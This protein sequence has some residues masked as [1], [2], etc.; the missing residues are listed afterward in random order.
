MNIIERGRGFVQWL[1]E[2][3]QRSLWDWRRC[4][5]C[6][7]DQTIRNGGYW[8]RP[9]TFEGRQRVRVQRHRCY[10]CGR[11]YIEERAWLVRGSWYG[12][13]VH[14]WAVDCW[15]YARSSLRRSAEMARSWLG[16]QERWGMW[17]PWEEGAAG[18][19]RCR[20]SAS[21]VQRWLGRAGQ[22]ARESVPEHLQGLGS[23]GQFGSDGLWVR[24]RGGG[25]RVVLSLVDSVSGLVWGL[26]VAV[27]EESAAEW[28]KLFERAREAGL[29]W[30]KLNGLTSDGAQGLLA[31]LRQTL[32][33]VHHQRCVWHFWRSLGAELGKAVAKAAKG[34]TKEAAETARRLAREELTALLHAVIDAPSYAQAEQSL[35]R[36]G[37]HPLG[38]Q[39]AK[40]VNEQLDR[41][42]FALLP[43]HQGLLRIAPEWLWRD[44]RLRPSR[45]RNQGSEQGLERAALLWMVAHEF[46]PA[47]WRSER[48]RR[49]KHPGQS[50][51]EVAGGRPGAISYLDALE[52]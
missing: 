41:L 3:H 34:L 42:L 39:L 13:E 25:K 29:L 22:K 49:Y 10:A 31:Y 35:M 26:V 4:P 24:L 32:E 37:Q 27:G 36:L 17:R 23:S 21:T 11:S 48:K 15:V 9:W 45:G 30:E 5:R 38:Q 44:F 50:P 1:R 16:R 46:T 43:E 6:G 20:L 33:W 18:G 14:R 7:K 51:L 12:R 52:V 47:Q 28:Q 8:R 2:L 40:K 19:E